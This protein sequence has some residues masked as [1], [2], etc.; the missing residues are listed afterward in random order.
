MRLPF[1]MQWL[2]IAYRKGDRTRIPWQQVTV[3]P[4]FPAIKEQDEGAEWPTN[5]MVSNGMTIMPSE[6]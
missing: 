2:Y 4:V 5:G 3:L 1:H 6:S